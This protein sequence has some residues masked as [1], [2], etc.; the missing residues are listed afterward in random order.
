MAEIT[1]K[2]KAT[3]YKLLADFENLGILKEISGG[4]RNKFYSFSE[5]LA[6]FN[7]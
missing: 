4:Q 5:Y 6:L 3:N 7:S 2:S 1:G